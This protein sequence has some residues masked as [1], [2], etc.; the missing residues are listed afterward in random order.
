MCQQHNQGRCVTGA[1]TS[2]SNSKCG[3]SLDVRDPVVLAVLDQ[4]VLVA[5][6]SQL[7][8]ARPSLTVRWN[9]LPVS[10]KVFVSIERLQA[11]ESQ[12][13]SP[14]VFADRTI[15]TS[16]GILRPTSRADRQVGV[17]VPSRSAN[18]RSR[19]ICVV[20]LSRRRFCSTL[21]PSRKKS[22]VEPV[23]LADLVSQGH[24][25]Q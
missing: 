10:I 15:L 6:V 21:Y 18:I 1:L 17:L 19:S 2:L 20:R 14:V 3:C 22:L 25:L 8:Q 12:G 16:S 24:L 5:R 9:E 11:V 23:F 7:S 4:F 13:S